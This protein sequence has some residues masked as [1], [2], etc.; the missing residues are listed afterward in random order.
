MFAQSENVT[1]W[2][3]AANV[4]DETEFTDVIITKTNTTEI[5]VTFKSG[6]ITYNNIYILVVL[7]VA[8]VFLTTHDIAVSA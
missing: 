7:T 4:T 5:K 1:N 8:I 6:T 3:T 2:F